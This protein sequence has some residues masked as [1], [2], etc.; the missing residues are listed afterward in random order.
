MAN[1]FN[2][3]IDQEYVGMPFQEILAAASIRQK[4]GD[5]NRAAYDGM[6]DLLSA[7]KAIPTSPDEE[8]LKQS[9]LAA[10]NLINQ[11]VSDQNKISDPNS[12]YNFT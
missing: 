10:Q 5:T 8:Y 4:T 3:I 9:E 2:K 7:N 6:N 12:I 1:R 11:Y